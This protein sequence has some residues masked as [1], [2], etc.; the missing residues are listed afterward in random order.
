M[1]APEVRYPPA[2][3]TTYAFAY[4]DVNVILSRPRNPRLRFTSKSHPAMRAWMLAMRDV[5]MSGEE[6]YEH[7]HV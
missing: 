4:N 5:F 7:E 2:L 3:V 6:V 1:S